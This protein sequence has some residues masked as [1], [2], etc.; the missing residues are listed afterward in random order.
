MSVETDVKTRTLKVI[1]HV[2][3]KIPNKWTVH[4]GK[5]T[6]GYLEGDA[7]GRIT[8]A[9]R[10]IGQNDDETTAIDAAFA[11]RGS[12]RLADDHRLPH[13]FSEDETHEN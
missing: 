2:K 7:I 4:N 3:L 1:K 9:Y 10:I 13:I 5:G 12:R 11:G 6:K 8:A